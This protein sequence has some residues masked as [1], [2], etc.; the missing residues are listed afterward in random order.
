VTS[1][2][3]SRWA[4]QRLPR[5][6]NRVSRALAG[7][8]LRLWRWRIDGP[9]PDVP[10]AVIVVA[11]HTSNWDFIPGALGMLA[12]GLRISWLAKHT[13]FRWPLGP[14]LRWLGGVAVRRDE[15]AGTVGQAVA[16]FN[17]HP[18]LLLALTPEGTRRAVSRW[19]GGFARIAAGAA[20]PAVPV[21]L[22]WGTRRLRIG[23]TLTL[24]GNPETDE[25]T[26]R[27]WFAGTRAL[28]PEKTNL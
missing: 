6:G 24:S 28:R 21:A 4:P 7:T 13:V 25:A 8:V 17:E 11:P 23:Q 10:K 20:V 19:R 27:A 12:L 18:A 14:V 1:E 22:D 26:L 16:L 9:F 5:R 15:R 2:S 3:G